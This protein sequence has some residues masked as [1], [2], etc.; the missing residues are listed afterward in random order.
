MPINTSEIKMLRAA[1]NSDTGANGGLMSSSEIPSGVTSNLFPNASAADRQNGTTQYRKVFFKIAN[2]DNLPLLSARVWQDS[3]TAG[4]DNVTFCAGSQRDTQSNISGAGTYYGM[5]SLF[6]GV[7]AGATSIQVQVEDGAVPIFRN[8]GLIRMSN[9]ADP[10]SAGDEFWTRVD[11]APTVQGNVVT[12]HLA[13]PVPVTFLSGVKVSSVM[14]VGDVKPTL[15]NPVVTSA[16]GS[17]ASARTT[18]NSIGTVEQSWTLTFT[19]SLAFDIAGDTVGTV[20][21]GNVSGGASPNNPVFNKPYF[22]IPAGAFTGTFQAGDSVVFQTHPE[23]V[24]V[25]LR[26]VI[27]AGTAAASNNNM[28]LYIDGESD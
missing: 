26:R 20:G 27:P 8:G 22:T 1:T 7:I 17:F 15:S 14:E 4:A 9:R 25:W 5:G 18:L 16:S 2:V 11:Q 12:L 28:S 24:P 21:S 13:T 6:S 3:N 10:F 23:A 19:S